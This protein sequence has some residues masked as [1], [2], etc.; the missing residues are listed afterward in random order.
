MAPVFRQGKTPTLVSFSLPLFRI[1]VRPGGLWRNPLVRP[2]DSHVRSGIPPSSRHR[3]ARNSVGKSQGCHHSSHNVPRFRQRGEFFVQLNSFLC[4]SYDKGVDFLCV[5]LFALY[6]APHSYR[7]FD[8]V[9]LDKNNSM[10][11][12]IEVKLVQLT[13]LFAD[14]RGEHKD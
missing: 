5:C 11:G 1:S 2:D 12:V 13:Q 7:R 14:R 6:C 10:E 4:A 3:K 9:D 8:Q